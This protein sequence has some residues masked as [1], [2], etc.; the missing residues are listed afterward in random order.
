MVMINRPQAVG[1]PRDGHAIEVVQP[2]SFLVTH[3]QHELPEDDHIPIVCDVQIETATAFAWFLQAL[4]E[5]KFTLAVAIRTAGRMA[6]SGTRPE[7]HRR[8]NFSP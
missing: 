6:A 3:A 5:G 4:G 2:A 8:T 7:N 1:L